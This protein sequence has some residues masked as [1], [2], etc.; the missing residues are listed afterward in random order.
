MPQNRQKGFTLLELL[1]VVAIIGVV[2]AIAIPQ[3]HSYRAKTEIAGVMSNCRSLFRAF[4]I[5]Y[6][7]NDAEYP[8]NPGEY[9]NP[10]WD[11]D[12]TTFDPLIDKNNLGGVAFE[13]DIKQLKN[14]VGNTPADIA[15]RVYFADPSY[16]NYYLVMPWGRDPSTVFIVSTSDNVTD[17]A[18]NLI[19]GGNYLDGVFIWKDGKLKYQ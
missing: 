9:G 6:M 17:K 18:G 7:E 10:D 14:N 19:D 4:V 5:Y 16:Q 2:S 1:V 15:R 13:I 3:Y 12:L 8:S 11:F